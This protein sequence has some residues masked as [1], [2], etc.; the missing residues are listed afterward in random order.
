MEKAGLKIE[1][2]ETVVTE[3]DNIKSYL[4]GEHPYE[5]FGDPKN[6]FAFI[7]PDFI[8]KN[9]LGSRLLGVFRFGH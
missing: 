4:S 2:M 5:G 9:L 7:D 6:I 8:H 1:H 3:I